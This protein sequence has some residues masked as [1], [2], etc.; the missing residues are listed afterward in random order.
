MMMIMM[1]RSGKM[2]FCIGM[3]EF[4]FLWREREFED[5]HTQVQGNQAVR[6]A[7]AHYKLL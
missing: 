3:D 6:G 4:I 2:W 5:I 7:L 1:T